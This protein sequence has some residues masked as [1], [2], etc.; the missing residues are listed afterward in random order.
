MKADQDQRRHIL[1]NFFSYLRARKLLVSVILLCIL[2]QVAYTLSI[3]ISYPFIFDNAVK[4]K[5][6]DLLMMIAMFFLVG[7]FI[8]SLADYIAAY[9]AT[10][11]TQN[12]VTSL[13]LDLLSHIAKLSIDEFQGISARRVQTSF[14]DHINAIE[15]AMISQSVNVIRAIFL[16]I[17]PF[18]LICWLNWLIGILLFIA[19]LVILVFPRLVR[20]KYQDMNALYDK[21]E[22]KLLDTMKDVMS[23]NIA[24]KTYYLW[25]FWSKILSLH[26]IKSAAVEA[27]ANF[28]NLIAS[29]SLL[30]S[31][32]L[33]RLLI[34]F[35]GGL[36]VIYGQITIV[37]VFSL[38]TLASFILFSI[39]TVANSLPVI[40]K[41][42]YGFRE[43][44]NILQTKPT[45]TY[46]KDAMM[47]P[48]IKYGIELRNVG[49]AYQ[50]N[51]QILKAISLKIRLGESIAFV[52]PSGS[53]KSTL[54]KLL[55]RM[56]DPTAGKILVDDLYS[57]SQ[58]NERSYLEKVAAVLQ[59]SLLFN[60]SI[61][62]N[63]KLGRLK[64][65]EDD[66]ILA[67]K[68]VH[69]HDEILR[70]PN[71]YNTIVGSLG[72]RLSGGQCQR[73]ALARGLIRQSQILLLD[74]VTS[75]VDALAGEVI[76]K[77]LIECMNR[78]TL[79]IATHY[80]YIAKYVQTIYV[81]DGG[82]IVEHGT[83][84]ALMGRGGLYAKLS[85]KQQ[86]IKIT[87]GN[88]V[89]F[90]NLDFLSEIPILQYCDKDLIKKLSKQF[91]IDNLEAKQTIFEQDSFGD[92]FYLIARGQVEILK[93]TKAQ[94]EDEVVAV[95]EEGDYFGEIA[96]LFNEK[97][98]ATV[99]TRTPCV[100]LSMYRE[101]FDKLLAESPALYQR[102]KAMAAKRMVE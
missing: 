17:I 3:P 78:R 27:K 42:I 13:R 21:E 73:I 76:N 46:P 86:R 64:A 35:L 91:V 57:I 70:F 94:A 97:R 59:D 7:F 2:V 18:I 66:V 16:I 88:K 72:N 77:T 52:G 47:L 33:I 75:Q 43:I 61:F 62:D 10:K 22:A 67:A 79:V 54:V 11:L 32:I 60:L 87:P 85:A 6:I 20:R 63:I 44:N 102:I 25:R 45:I 69:M 28:Y 39:D 53:G 90:I 48:T 9:M 12:V 4:N 51:I 5:D 81:L 31:S 92:K 95:L 84:D 99:K 55:M 68:Q 37:I 56:Y 98:T 49:F 19:V 101:Q 23:A 93:H 89:S 74:E 50:K 29:H 83:H 30:T 38:L 82:R 8:R 36:A 58:I 100:L 65:N 40:A 34:I 71:G 96:L 41:A 24:V 1:S 15:L 14:A 80:L 26:V